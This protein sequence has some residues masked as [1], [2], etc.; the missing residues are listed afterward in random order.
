MSVPKL[1]DGKIF[2]VTQYTSTALVDLGDYRTFEEAL[3][4][5]RAAGAVESAPPTQPH[6]LSSATYPTT[7][8]GR[9]I[10]GVEFVDPLFRGK[11]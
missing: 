6:T 11:S 2:T 7:S 10:I 5:A 8:G 9:I 4:A 1:N 3:A